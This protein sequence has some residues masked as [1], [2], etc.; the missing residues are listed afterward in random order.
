[1]ETKIRWWIDFFN[2]CFFK[3]KPVPVDELTYRKL[4][5]DTLGSY[6]VW[7]NDSK[8]KTEIRLN[9]VYVNRDISDTLQNLVHQM[10]HVYE[11]VYINGNKTNTWYHSKAFRATM[12]IIGI[13]TNPKGCHLVVRDPF[14]FMLQKHG[15]EFNSP[16]DEKGFIIIPP[17]PTAKGKSKLRK[18]SCGCQ[19]VRVGKAKFDATCDICLNK[20][21]LVA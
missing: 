7:L 6:K 16:R 8:M 3:D 19:N 12:E 4:R 2:A 15:V 1:M 17:K 14:R 13:I 5:V 9:S 21:E 10:V 18:W 11:V 20:F